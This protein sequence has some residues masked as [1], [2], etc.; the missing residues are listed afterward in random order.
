MTRLF[1]A[2]L[3]LATFALNGCDNRTRDD[4]R[5]DQIAETQKDKIKMFNLGPRPNHLGGTQSTTEE[6]PG[7]RG[8]YR[9]IG[10]PAKVRC[11]RLKEDNAQ[12]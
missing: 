12:I 6:P 4:V 8:T 2:A 10:V 3:C 11:R 5:W 7:R 9:R 1:V